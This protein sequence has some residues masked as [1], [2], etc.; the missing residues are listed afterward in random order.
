MDAILLVLYG[1]TNK[2]PKRAVIVALQPRRDTD[3][4]R[5][6]TRSR[7]RGGKINIGSRCGVGD[8][9]SDGPAVGAGALRAMVPLKLPME[10]Q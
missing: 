10:H 8:A 1:L 7:H 9:R 3:A 5:M 4:L 6:S 2:A